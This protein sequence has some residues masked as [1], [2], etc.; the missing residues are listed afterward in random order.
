MTLTIN[1]FQYSNWYIF[2]VEAIILN[3]GNL[4]ILA[5]SPKNNNPN[6]SASF[7]IMDKFLFVLCSWITSRSSLSMSFLLGGIYVLETF[8]DN[9]SNFL[10]LGF[11]AR[12][13]G[14][15]SDII[16]SAI[17]IVR[18]FL[19]EVI[20]FWELPS[21]PKTSEP[22]EKL[23]ELLSVVIFDAEVN[24]DISDKLVSV[25]VVILLP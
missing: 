2:F 7:L 14:R 19:P 1:N 11:W 24:P 20:N 4:D 13:K 9:S 8:L 25:D 23:L 22:S 5:P 15:H 12:L 21:I 17:A 3:Y 10:S 16:R 18:Q 6:M